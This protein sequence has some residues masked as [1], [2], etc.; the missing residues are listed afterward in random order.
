MNNIDKVLSGG[1]EDLNH[2]REPPT[3]EVLEGEALEG[4]ALEGKAIEGEVLEGEAL[5][6]EVTT[7]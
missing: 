4:E 7:I 1:F 2:R 5:E 3:P 6:G